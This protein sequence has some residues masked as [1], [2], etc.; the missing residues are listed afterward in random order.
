MVDEFDVLEFRS[1]SFRGQ[2]GETQIFFAVSSQAA[3]AQDEL[4][5]V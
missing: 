1:Q 2:K 3:L 4:I 5:M